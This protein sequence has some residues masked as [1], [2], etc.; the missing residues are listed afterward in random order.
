MAETSR[1]RRRG[2]PPRPDKPPKVPQIRF[3]LP[4]G[5]REYLRYLVEV[6]GWFGSGID[7]AARHILIRE[8]N[9]M[10]DARYHERDFPE[11]Q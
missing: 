3:T 2:R 4:R 5:E 10:R 11:L 1:N 7:D 8:L 6:K 9:K